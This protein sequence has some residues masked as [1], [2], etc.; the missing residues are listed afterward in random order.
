MRAD[1]IRQL[2]D[3]NYWATARILAASSRA[4]ADAVLRPNGLAHSSIFATLVHALESEWGWRTRSQERSSPT[5]LIAASEF[6]DLA[7]LRRRW[8]TEERAMRGYLATLTDG[9]LDSEIEYR[10]T[11]GKEYVNPLWQILLHLLN[12]G[13]QHRAEAAAELTRL[14]CSPGDI[15]FMI[16][17]RTATPPVP[18]QLRITA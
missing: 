15:D 6:A 13:T 8:S 17:L 12:H 1:Q 18:G 16:Y 11:K 4:N 14:G 10:S 5:T 2:Y 9:L 3:Y 7:A